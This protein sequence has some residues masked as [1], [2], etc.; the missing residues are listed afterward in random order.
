MRLELQFQGTD[1][2]CA[3]VVCRSQVRLEYTEGLTGWTIR[4]VANERGGMNERVANVASE[5]SLHHCSAS[6]S[7]SKISR[8]W[9]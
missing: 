9:Q 5:R 4:C 3:G 2:H 1:V 7:E 6:G 8:S